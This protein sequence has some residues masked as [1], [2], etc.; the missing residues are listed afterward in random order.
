MAH[1]WPGKRTCSLPPLHLQL[2]HLLT[3]LPY[4]TETTLNLISW[5]I[6]ICSR[7]L[8][9]CHPKYKISPG[10]WLIPLKLTDL[11]LK[12]CTGNAKVP[13][14][15][16]LQL[17]SET[18]VGI[19]HLQREKSKIFLADC[20]WSWQYV[21]PYSVIFFYSVKDSLSHRQ[22]QMGLN[23]GL[24]ANCITLRLPP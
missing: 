5:K 7:F 17:P 8:L 9:I 2:F 11:A 21:A 19:I 6:P 18:K 1:L 12:I 20:P 10:P 22:Q 24:E 16:T 15:T 4:L 14:W 23:A 13:T 3:L